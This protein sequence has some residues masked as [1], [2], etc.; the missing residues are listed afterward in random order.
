MDTIDYDRDNKQPNH[1]RQSQRFPKGMLIPT[2]SS[3]KK[4]GMYPNKIQEMDASFDYKV[5]IGKSF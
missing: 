1:N 2:A 3:Q 4:E 5:F